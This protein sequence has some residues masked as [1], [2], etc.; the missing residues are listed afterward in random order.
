[1]IPQLPP[2]GSETDHAGRGTN[3]YGRPVQ[4]ST[5]SLAV[6]RFLA[7]LA[8]SDFLRSGESEKLAMRYRKFNLQALLDTSAKAA[9]NYEIYYMLSSTAIFLG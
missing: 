5:L 3:R 7:C 8:V 1:M 2:L 6:C 9:G 4:V